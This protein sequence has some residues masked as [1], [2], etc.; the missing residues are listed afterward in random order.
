MMFTGFF[1]VRN[2]KFRNV[3]GYS[4]RD[5]Y[6]YDNQAEQLCVKGK[7]RSEIEVSIIRLGMYNGVHELHSMFVLRIKF[8]R[9]L[10]PEFKDLF[11]SDREIHEQL[12]H[13]ATLV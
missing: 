13:L 7:S 8:N 2:S 9:E 12:R 10:P 6:N 5:L 11:S 3:L 1:S 4:L